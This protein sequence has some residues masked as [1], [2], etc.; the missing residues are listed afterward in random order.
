MSTAPNN[1]A[2][3]VVIEWL[4]AMRRGDRDAVTE[5][6]R[7]DVTW[8]GIV[9][10]AV[11]R[12]R[13]EVLDMLEHRL[14]VGPPRAE[15]L[16]VIRGDTCVVLGVRSDDLQVI[17][18]VPVPGQLCNVFEVRDGRMT[19]VRDFVRRAL[20]C[21]PPAPAN[22][23]GRSASPLV[24]GTYRQVKIDESPKITC[25]RLKSSPSW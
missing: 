22:R 15:A 1:H 2:M 5:C 7:P 18:D 25:P 23:N 9:P 14:A 6:F 10:D 11:C 16:E 17:A 3:A 19:A 20:P 12:G 4:D 13:T 8:R 21:T 24:D